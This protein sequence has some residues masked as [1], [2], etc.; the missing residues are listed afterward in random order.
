MSWR[1][2]IACPNMIATLDDYRQVFERHHVEI[3]VSDAPQQLSESDLTPVIGLYDGIIVGD[4]E[5]TRSVLEQAIRLRVI[6]KWGVGIDNIDKA[7]ARDHDVIVTNTPG[8]FGNEV[9]DVVIG[10]LVLLARRLHVIDRRVRAGEWHKPAGLSLT[11]KTVGIVGLGSIGIEV[12]RRTLAMRMQ[13]IGTDPA[14][15]AR[16]AA[17][18]L[19]AV[20]VSLEE[21]VARSEFIVLTCPLTENTHH[22]LDADRLAQTQGGVRIVNVSRGA[23]IEESALVAA[24]R[25]EHVAGAALDVF[26]DEPLPPDSPLCRMERVI[27]GSHNASNTIE[28]V[29]RVS[30][31]AIE[32]LLRG[33]RGTS[34]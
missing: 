22:L 11:E 15:T 14:S 27:L 21:L 16:E 5:I 24:L 10:Y 3:D 23:L 18:R 2:L 8:V 33:L 4:D 13:V 28:A 12:A 6:S 30:E 19:G 1:V 7:A 31:L 29:R 34:R 17:D 9:A 20:V 26:E 32:N 25:R